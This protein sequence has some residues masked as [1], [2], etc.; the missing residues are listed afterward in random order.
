MRFVFFAY[1]VGVLEQG[2]ALDGGAAVLGAE[3]VDCL[4]ELLRFRLLL[5]RLGEQRGLDKVLS[6]QIGQG[7]AQQAQRR[8]AVP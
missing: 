4:V 2:T 1:F 7:D 5:L 6:G 8:F 3:G